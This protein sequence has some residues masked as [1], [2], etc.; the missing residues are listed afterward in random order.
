M[1]RDK[2][3]RY[4]TMEKKLVIACDHGGYEL[5][6]ALISHLSESGYTV[7]DLGCDSPES[8]DYPVY[9]DKLCCALNR[10][11]APLGILVCGTGLGMSIAA[12]KHKGIRAV[13]CSD[14][15]SAKMGRVHNNANVLCMGGRVV[16][17]ERG[18]AL[19]D[20][21]LQ[22]EFEGG[23]HERRVVMLN[24]LDEAK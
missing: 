8:V 3:E 10:G 18:C 21:F 6:L 7:V 2:K 14:T 16:D 5:K 9:A 20:A 12:N 22:A 19:A 13:C 23:R 24:A 4:I 15:F 1:G 17:A 11:D